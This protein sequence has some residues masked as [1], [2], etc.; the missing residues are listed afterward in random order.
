ML[1]S[2][3]RA[4]ALLERDEREGDRTLWN[5]YQDPFFDPI[6]GDPR[7]VALLRQEGLPTT[8]SRPIEALGTRAPLPSQ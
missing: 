2:K 8:L 4:L 1:G 5:C 7:F 6:R 3:E